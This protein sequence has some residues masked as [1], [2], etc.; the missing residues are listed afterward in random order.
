MKSIN[1]FYKVMNENAVS[2]I[3]ILSFALT[4][5]FLWKMNAQPVCRGMKQEAQDQNST[6]GFMPGILNNVVISETGF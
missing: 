3:L 2:L 5:T 1:L 4:T 6:Y